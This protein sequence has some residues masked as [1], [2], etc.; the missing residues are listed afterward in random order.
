MPVNT[1]T[2]K[3]MNPRMLRFRGGL[4]CDD[5]GLGKTLTLLSLIATHSPSKS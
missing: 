5:V 1:A 2:D 4:I 3:W